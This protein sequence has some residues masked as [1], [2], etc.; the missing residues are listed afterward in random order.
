MKRYHKD[1]ITEA[2]KYGMIHATLAL[3]KNHVKL[4]CTNKAGNKKFL[5]TSATPSD[6]RG[7]KHHTAM[8]KRWSNNI[9][10]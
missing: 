8:V 3:K 9:D 2:Y 4:H 1:L 7:R 10:Y 5:T 6:V